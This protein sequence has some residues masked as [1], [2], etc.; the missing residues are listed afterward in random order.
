MWRRGRHETC[1]LLGCYAA[2]SGNPLP[3]FRD[4]VSVPSSRVKKSQKRR[5]LPFFD[6]WSL[7]DGT[8]TASRNVGKGLPLEAAFYP[9]RTQISSASRRQ[10]E[11]TKGKSV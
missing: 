3:T 9:R 6:F 1:V 5:I 8:D 11:I 4:N 2:S 10:P 7:E